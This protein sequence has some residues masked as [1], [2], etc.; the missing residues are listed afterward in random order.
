MVVCSAWNDLHFYYT[1]L[2]ETINKPIKSLSLLGN[3]KLDWVI[4]YCGLIVSCRNVRWSMEY[5][6]THKFL[7]LQFIISSPCFRPN[8]LYSLFC[9][10]SI[11]LYIAFN[12]TQTK[13]NLQLEFRSVC[14]WVCFL[15]HG[16]AFMRE[17]FHWNLMIKPE[18]VCFYPL[19][20]V[21][22]AE[23]QLILL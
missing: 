4:T 10:H 19:P 21:P 23:F 20:W 16:D 8:F 1:N 6:S 7:F 22:S 14:M 2:R 17:Q 5:S 13:I 18:P 12:Y 9:L 11:E 3:K 15:K